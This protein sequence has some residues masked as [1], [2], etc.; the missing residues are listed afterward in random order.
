MVSQTGIK[1]L[2]TWKSLINSLLVKW[3]IIYLLPSKIN[4]L[5]KFIVNVTNYL[6]TQLKTKDTGLL[7][8]VLKM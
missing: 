7:I 1:R 6:K 8:F 2:S 4:V 5:G 3:Y